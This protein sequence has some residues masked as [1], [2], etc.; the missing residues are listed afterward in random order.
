[1]RVSVPLS[2]KVYQTTSQMIEIGEVKDMEPLALQNDET[3][4]DLSHP[5]TVDRQR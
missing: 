5:R 2:D 4:L 3:L 1:M